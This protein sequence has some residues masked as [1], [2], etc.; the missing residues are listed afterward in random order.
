[1]A[2]ALPVFRIDRFDG[3]MPIFSE[4][5]PS[6]IL[7]RAIITS[8]LTIIAIVESAVKRVVG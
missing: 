3:V 2:L 6:D 5:S 7:R 8:R 4:S 1:M